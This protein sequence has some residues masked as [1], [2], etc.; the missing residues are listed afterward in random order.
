MSLHLVT[1]GFHRQSIADINQADV[2][3]AADG[4]VIFVDSGSVTLNGRPWLVKVDGELV[5]VDADVSRVWSQLPSRVRDEMVKDPAGALSAESVKSL[6]S[7]RVPSIAQAYFVGSEGS[8]DWHVT[9][10]LR[11]FV[12]VLADLND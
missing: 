3:N 4:S 10:E 12:E 7:E 2:A 6:S 5:D 8:A 1:T 9:G 11:R